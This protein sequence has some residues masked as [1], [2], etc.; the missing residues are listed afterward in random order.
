MILAWALAGLGLFLLAPA[1]PARQRL[2]GLLG[3][4]LPAPVLEPGRG[5][6]LSFRVKLISCGGGSGV[7]GAVLAGPVPGA[8]AVLVA[9]VAIGLGRQL[10]AERAEQADRKRLIDVVAAIAAEQAAGAGLAAALVQS[11]DSAGR[12]QPALRQ[13]ARAATV[14]DDPAR[15][16]AQERLLVPLAVALSVAGRSGAGLTD[17]LMRVRSELRSQQE[18]RQATAQAVAGPRSSALLL[19]V[20]PAV[21][22]A[23]GAALG[24]R[25]WHVLTATSGGLLAL[26]AGVLLELAGLLWTIRLTR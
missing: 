22:L 25:P 11:A 13:A 16:L 15:G 17:V 20:L 8:L 26:A 21:G 9:L 7:A 5:V 24:A 12:W 23:M 14:G 6:R 10:V 19:S 18:C 1:R 2:A 3:D 4:R